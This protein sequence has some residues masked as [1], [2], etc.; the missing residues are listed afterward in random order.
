MLGPVCERLGI[1]IIEWAFPDALSALIARTQGGGY[2]IGVN[3]SHARNRRR[4]SVAHEIGH[5]VLRHEAAYYLEIADQSAFGD[6][7]GYR[8]LD[9]RAANTFAASLLM[10]ERW[11]RRDFKKV[12]FAVNLAKQYKVSEEAMSFRLM[13][14]KLV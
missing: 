12:P 3:N 10:D 11:L 4:F 2:V 5:A 1:S 7:P 6:P 14:L 13:N 8:Y 9:E